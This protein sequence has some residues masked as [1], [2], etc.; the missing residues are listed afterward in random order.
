MKKKEEKT[1]SILKKKGNQTACV[2]DLEI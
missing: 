2:V 1:P